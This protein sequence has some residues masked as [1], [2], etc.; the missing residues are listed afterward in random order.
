MIRYEEVCPISIRQKLNG[1]DIGEY[2]NFYNNGQLKELGKFEKS[3]KE[4][5]N[6]IGIFF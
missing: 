1:D 4:D 3:F 5:T 6:L 2:K